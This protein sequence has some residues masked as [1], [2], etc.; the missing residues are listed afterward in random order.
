M[1]PSESNAWKCTSR[2]F[3]C[4]PRCG[5]FPKQRFFFLEMGW[6]EVC[7]TCFFASNIWSWSLWVTYVYPDPELKRSEWFGKASV[8]VCLHV[9]VYLLCIWYYSSCCWSWC[10]WWWWCCCLW[11]QWWVWRSLASGLFRFKS[12]C[13]R[14][15][16]YTHIISIIIVIAIVILLL[17][18]TL[19]M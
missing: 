2:L 18:F 16:M 19:V 5:S 8:C 12:S 10:C 6:V 17:L 7:W 14:A 1:P 13:F 4:D 9:C 15:E 11:W 3:L